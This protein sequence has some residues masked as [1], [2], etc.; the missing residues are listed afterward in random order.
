M[1]VPAY[2]KAALCSAHPRSAICQCQGASAVSMETPPASRQ[3]RKRASEPRASER[4]ERS[5]GR[6]SGFARL[7]PPPAER[8][9][10]A[11]TTA[12]PLPTILHHRR[13]I[14][15]FRRSSGALRARPPP[16]WR[17]R[18]VAPPNLHACPA[19]KSATVRRFAT[20]AAGGA[21][22][23][24]PFHFAGGLSQWV[25]FRMARILRGTPFTDAPPVL[26][27]TYRSFV[28]SSFQFHSSSSVLGPS[29]S[30]Q[31]LLSR[32]FNP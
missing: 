23:R 4:A 19:G 5:R 21:R 28:S 30:F 2:V 32:I 13:A 24:V 18:L 8:N 3:R 11:S 15:P 16:L 27:E 17:N 26:A 12:V 20:P 31:T 7:P 14:P 25:V 10:R 9:P 6:P 1:G 29:R 22:G